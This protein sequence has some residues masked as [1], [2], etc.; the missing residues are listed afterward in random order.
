VENLL[1]IGS[2][3]TKKMEQSMTPEEAYV[4]MLPKIGLA[5]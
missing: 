3:K 2:S 5:V 4:S 1:P